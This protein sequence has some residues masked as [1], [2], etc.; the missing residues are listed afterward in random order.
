M[1][2]QTVITHAPKQGVSMVKSSDSAPITLGDV[3]EGT[4]AM[5]G[6]SVR[7][8]LES[9]SRDG[10]ATVRTAT[11]GACVLF[12]G[13]LSVVK[14]N[15]ATARVLMLA[16]ERTATPITLSLSKG[17][18]CDWCDAPATHRAEWP[19]W[20]DLMCRHHALRYGR[21]ECVVR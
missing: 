11:G 4:S 1:E 8:T 10:M 17:S 21:F 6:W 20:I 19:F 5:W 13:A 18:V 15:N 3:V 14:P 12:V 7:G 9:V 16:G 2:A